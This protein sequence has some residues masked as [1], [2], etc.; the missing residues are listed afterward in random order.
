MTR[1]CRSWQICVARDLVAR[2]QTRRIRPFRR[3]KTNNLTFMP[4]S[5]QRKIVALFFTMLAGAFSG[6]AA[7]IDFQPSAEVHGSLVLLGDIAKVV[8]G[9]ATQVATLNR[10]EL[11]PAPGVDK[12]TT[13]RTAYVRQLL[14]LHGVGP[15]HHRFTGATAIR[16][17]CSGAKTPVVEQPTATVV[18]LP[19]IVFTKRAISQGERVREID[20]ELRSVEKLPP[21]VAALQTTEVAVGQ[22]ATR[23]ID[24]D[25]PLDVRH[26][27]KPVLVRRGQSVSVVAKAAGVRARTTA[28]ALEDGAHGD[29]VLVESLETKQKYSAM[30]TDHQQVEV[31]AKAVTAFDAPRGVARRNDPRV[32]KENPTIRAGETIPTTTALKK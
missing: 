30:V 28:R 17:S 31:L 22:E 23:S 2:W 8:D 20:L 6:D 15:Q 16:I 32:G 4:P 21:G 5:L 1:C 29:L 26:L 18:E 25:E 9:N 11:F 24:A 19:R 3:G 13:V 27:R 7:E 10:I 12:S 14:Q